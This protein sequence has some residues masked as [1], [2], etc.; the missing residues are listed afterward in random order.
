MI[1]WEPK[2]ATLPTVNRSGKRQLPV[3]GLVAVAIVALAAA[4]GGSDSS[5]STTTAA[6]AAEQWAN[7]L[8]AATNTY[9]ASLKS[10]GTTLTSGSLG[11]G[12]LDAVVSDATASTQA[13]ADSVKA[14][15]T[16]PV[17]D[18]KA[19]QIFETLRGELSKDADT[20]KSATSSVS[21]ATEVLN[22]VSVVTGTLGTA[23]TQIKDAFDQVKQLDP[24]SA[25]GEAF[26]NAPACATLTG[27]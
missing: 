2:R 25:V 11:K 26:Q 27:S 10:M 9:L 1:R 3:I 21:S 14:L 23:G 4:C 15:G 24:K 17:S 13:F 16:P 6:A 19:K 8:C 22:A 7:G 12:V 5:S 18:S 20:I